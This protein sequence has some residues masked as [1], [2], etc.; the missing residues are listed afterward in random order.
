MDD[1]GVEVGAPFCMATNGACWTQEQY[2]WA[3]IL[4]IQSHLGGLLE[5]VLILLPRTTPS[6]LHDVVPLSPHAAAHLPLICTVV[7]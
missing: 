5:L 7:G 4:Q 2:V 1:N 3:C 6:P